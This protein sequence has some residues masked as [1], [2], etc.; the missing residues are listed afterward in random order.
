MNILEKGMRKEKVGVVIE[1]E[2]EEIKELI[3]IVTAATHNK[4]IDLVMIIEEEIGT[5]KNQLHY[6]NTRR[7]PN[8]G[9]DLSMPG[10]F[11]SLVT[12][13]RITLL[14]LGRFNANSKNQSHKMLLL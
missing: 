9:C 5:A 6:A 1:L 8:S 2:T 7:I 3:Y 12:S 13:R 10:N 4:A 11:S 14:L